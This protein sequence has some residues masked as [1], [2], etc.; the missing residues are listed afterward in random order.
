MA[1]NRNNIANPVK[2]GVRR[3]RN[4]Q[5]GMTPTSSD[6]SIIR[7]SAMGLNLPADAQGNSAYYR[8]FIPGNTQAV[9]NITGPSIASYYSTGRFMPGSTI[10]WEPSVSFT[11]PGRVYVGFTDNPEVM[12]AINT[13]YNTWFGAKTQANYDLYANLIKGLGSLQ[14]FPVWQ[15]TTISMPMDTRR[16]RF[17]VNGSASFTA[18]DELDRC[19]QRVMYAAIDGTTAN[20]NTGSFWFHDVISVE[21]VT[22]VVT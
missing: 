17:D 11:T 16:K 10:R 8:S 20:V 13:R 15:E 2:G 18:A 4:T 9:A 6:S 22:G 12:V 21:G 19:A 3:K 5:P 14:S 1:P 7:Y